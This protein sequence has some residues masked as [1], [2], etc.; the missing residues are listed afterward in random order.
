MLEVAWFSNAV[1]VGT[2]RQSAPYFAF[3]LANSKEL[4]HI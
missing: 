3:R 4:S 2:V 1:I